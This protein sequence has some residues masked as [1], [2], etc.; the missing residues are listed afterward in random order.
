VNVQGV[1]NGFS[2]YIRSTTD[3]PGFPEE[4]KLSRPVT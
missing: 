2:V 4:I 1:K 3:N